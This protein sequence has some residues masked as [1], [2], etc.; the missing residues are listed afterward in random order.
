MT[1]IWMIWA[2]LDDGSMHEIGILSGDGPTGDSCDFGRKLV[3]DWFRDYNRPG[4]VEAVTYDDITPKPEPPRVEHRA[5]VCGEFGPD[6][7]GIA[8]VY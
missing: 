6:H 5:P 7:L 2:T 8:Y 4:S 3:D 1:R